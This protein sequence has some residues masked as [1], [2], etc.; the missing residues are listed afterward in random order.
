MAF[1]SNCVSTAI[2]GKMEEGLAKRYCDCMQVKMEVLYPDIRDAAALT[3]ADMAT[4]SMQRI[5]KDCL[6]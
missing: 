3:D 6:K 4:P 1:V 5:I 2:N